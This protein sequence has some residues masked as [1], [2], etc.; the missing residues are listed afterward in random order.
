MAP[1]SSILACRIPWTEEPVDYSPWGH[2]ELDA[3]QATSHVCTHPQIFNYSFC[4]D[5]CHKYISSLTVF[6]IVNATF[7]SV[8]KISSL[9]HININQTFIFNLNVTFSPNQLSLLTSLL[10]SFLLFYSSFWSLV[11][12][13]VLT[14]YF[15]FPES[16]S[17]HSFLKNIS[18]I[19]LSYCC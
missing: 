12:E 8:W 2:I 7:P 17:C 4:A 11:I 1:H 18:Q 16:I 13:L 6:L 10:S 19:W 9:G 15:L 5:D 14:P 3:T